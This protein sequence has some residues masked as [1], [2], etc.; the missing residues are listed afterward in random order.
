M[1]RS[2]YLVTAEHSA[3]AM[4]SGGLC[5]LST[6]S[7]VAF[8]E[9]TAYLYCTQSIKSPLTTVGAEFNIS[10]LAP[11]KIGQMIYVT[12]DKVEN[13]QR[14]FDFTL[15]AYDHHEQ[16]IAKATHRRVVINEDKFME[17]L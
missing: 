15:S 17:K 3:K 12:I 14:S 11:T 6:P 2:T 7:L 5:V 9:N 1:N 8:M 13:T 16:P 4:G 10:H